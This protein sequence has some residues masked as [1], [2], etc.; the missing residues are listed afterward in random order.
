MEQCGNVFKNS[1]AQ[2]QFLI[3]NNCVKIILNETNTPISRIRIRWRGEFREIK[4]VLCD[5]VGVARGDLAWLPIIPEKLMAWYFHIFDG[6]NT[7]SYGVKTGCNSFCFWQLDQEGVSIWLDVRNGGDGVLIEEP[8]LCAEVIEREGNDT[9]TPFHACKAFCSMMCDKPNLPSRP[10]FGLNNWYYA[11]GNISKATVIEDAYLAAELCQDATYRPFLLIDD[12]WQ[13]LREKGYNG[14]PFVPNEKFEDMKE[15]AEQ[16]DRIGCE[17]GLW[18]RPLLT[19]EE[20]PEF[21]Y[22]PRKTG[23]NGGLFLDPSNDEVLH[24][25]NNL[26]SGVAESG[27]KIIKYDFTAPDMMTHDIY[28]EIYLRHDLTP[29]G[30]HFAD[31]SNTNAQIIKKLYRTIQNAAKGA[32]IM[33]CNTY[34]HLAAGIHEIQRSG[35]DTSGKRWETTRKMGINTLAFRQPQNRNFFITDADCPALTEHAPIEMNLR[36]LEV[37]ALASNS[38]FVSVAPEILNKE[39]IKRT[40]NAFMMASNAS[41]M[42]PMDWLDTTCPSIYMSKG[43][44]YQFDWYTPTEGVMIY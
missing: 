28:D 15:V 22:H 32:Y 14:G 30:W 11:Y 7:H 6:N 36:F 26:V 2:V 40:A 17:P 23:S 37:S 16:I 29:N 35:L 18:I 44:K 13:K 33:G 8:L 10:I 4:R 9:E 43:E 38:L 24:Y 3:Q 5:S 41:G 20:F 39:Q 27:Y 1:E 19:K 34:N 12:G 25:V 21:W 42:E 31:R